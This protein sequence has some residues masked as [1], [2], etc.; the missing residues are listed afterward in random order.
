[1]KRNYICVVCGA[2]IHPKQ[3]YRPTSYCS[4]NCRNYNKYKNALERVLISLNKPTDDA[5]RIIK[6]DL[7]RC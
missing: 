2:P 4:D 3:F 6:G 1:M 5:R 7:F